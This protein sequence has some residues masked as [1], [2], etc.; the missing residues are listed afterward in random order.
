MLDPD[1][2]KILQNLLDLITRIDE[3]TKILKDLRTAL[4]KKTREQYG[5]FTDAECL[6]LLLERKWYRSLVKRIY[7]L[8]T[9]VNHHMTDRVTE[10]ANRYGETLPALENDVKKLETRVRSHLKKMGFAW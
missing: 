3:G 9:A 10:L 6:E 2:R 8:Y 1:D 7:E 4:D 5:K